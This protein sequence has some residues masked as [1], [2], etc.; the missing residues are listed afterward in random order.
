MPLLAAEVN[1]YPGDLLDRPE[2]GS[3]SDHAWWAL[4]TR[5]R[6]EKDL[7]RRL[8]AMNVPFYCPIIPQRR[9]ARG[10]RIR[11]AHLPLFSNYVFLY[12]DD[13]HRHQALTTNCISQCFT[14]E[15]GPRLTLDLKQIQSLIDAGVPLTPE[16]RLE[17]GEAVRI[18]S[19][20]FA[21]YEGY[22]VRRNGE[23][24]LVVAVNYLQQGASL[25]IDDCQVERI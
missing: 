21:G 6:R 11:T 3:Q 13:D 17:P 12:G 22:I 23:R 10:G 18:R 19:G 16:S 7:M 25:L 15:D 20:P 5:S 24:H 8:L 9:R 1:V 2:T 14:V 4:Y